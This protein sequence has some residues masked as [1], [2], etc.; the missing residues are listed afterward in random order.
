MRGGF[1][2]SAGSF[3]LCVLAGAAGA[4]GQDRPRIPRYDLARQP[5]AEEG[6]ELRWSNVAPLREANAGN[7]ERIWVVGSVVIGRTTDNYLVAF[8]ADTG[9]FRWIRQMG[10][11]DRDRFAP[12]F[13]VGK[14]YVVNYDEV[15]RLDAK[16]GAIEDRSKLPF[17]PCTGFV[18]EGDI[19]I[20]GAHNQRLYF[21]DGEKG[22]RLLN[23]P[24]PGYIP[25]TPLMDDPNERGMRSKIFFAD[26]SGR[27]YAYSKSGVP[28]WEYPAHGESI[29]KIAG[30]ISKVPNPHQLILI[31]TDDNSLYAVSQQT[32]FL[33]WQKRSNTSFE[34]AGYGV[35]H[36]DQDR[37]Y[38]R[39]SDRILYALDP[40]RGEDI[41]EMPNAGTFLC[42]GKNP[43]FSLFLLNTDG[44]ISEFQSEPFKTRRLGE[45]K[46]GFKPRLARR[47]Y[48]GGITLFAPNTEDPVLFGATRD[49]RFYAIKM[50]P[51]GDVR[52]RKKEE[53]PFQA[54][55]KA[56]PG[57]PGEKKAPKKDDEKKE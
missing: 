46:V 54:V 37:V 16:T 56:V 55:P 20:V 38:V 42:A 30:P 25:Y 1:R 34:E 40:N 2:A 47:F 44:S 21:L 31:P 10:R 12:T 39:D 35:M 52:E 8:D 6:L 50:N 33:R 24:L 41:W 5:L 9:A 32:G 15:Y 23:R 49:G 22:Y 4:F 57:K 48:L 3:L 45:E 27:V 28:Y 7:I 14:I 19:G 29:G 43:Q 11:T 17:T 51:D 53:M 13:S 26:T 18:R 36:P